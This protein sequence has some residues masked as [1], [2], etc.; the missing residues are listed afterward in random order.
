LVSGGCF[1]TFICIAD[2]IDDVAKQN[3]SIS[4]EHGLGVAKN[5]FLSYS[6]PE[7]M[8]KMMKTIKDLLDPNA[9]LNPYKVRIYKSC[10]LPTHPYFA[11]SRL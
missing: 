2:F 6:K 1:P 3:G 5:Q 11:L 4:A 7:G 9:I 8:I 10:L